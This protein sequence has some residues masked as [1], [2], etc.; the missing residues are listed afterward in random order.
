MSLYQE[1]GSS[2]I[3][4]LNLIYASKIKFIDPFHEVNGLNNL[5][6]YFT[7]LYENVN[8]INFDFEKL[9]ENDSVF[10][11]QWNMTLQHSKINKNRKFT[12]PGTTY[13]EVN[14]DN[15]IILHRDYFDAGAMLYENLPVIGRLIQWVKRKV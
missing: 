11:V 3:E 1:L 12:V 15:L 6:I 9:I 14:S 10:Y 2:N 5:K 8:D 13:C 4:K 7:T